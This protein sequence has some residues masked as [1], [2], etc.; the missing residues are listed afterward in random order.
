[1]K[2]SLEAMGQLVIALGLL[3]LLSFVAA[4][5]D[6]PSAPKAKP[7]CVWMEKAVPA[8]PGVHAESVLVCPKG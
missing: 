3:V 4:C 8:V 5:S 6:G 1:M 2:K 7:A